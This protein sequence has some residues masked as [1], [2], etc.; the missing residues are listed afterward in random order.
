MK[1]LCVAL[2]TIV[3]VFIIGGV[4]PTSAFAE[5]GGVSKLN[6]GRVVIKYE[7]ELIVAEID[8]A[9]LR[10]VV[11]EIETKT[12]AGF[13]LKDSSI[14]NNP[15]SIKIREATLEEALKLILK[16]IRYLN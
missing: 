1:K 14:V 5:T 10:Y 4:L 7:N 16:K 11:Q 15:L 9:P 3:Q 12:G 6:S 2:I 13:I 8:K